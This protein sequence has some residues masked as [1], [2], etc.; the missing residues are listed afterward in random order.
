MSKVR[1]CKHIGCDFST[2]KQWK[3]ELHEKECLLDPLKQN[4]KSCINYLYRDGCN[5]SLSKLDVGEQQNLF[6][7]SEYDS[8]LCSNYDY[9]FKKFGDEI[10]IS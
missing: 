2:Q 7:P 10:W 6:V 1:N 4:C 3:L 8:K 9:K 5:P